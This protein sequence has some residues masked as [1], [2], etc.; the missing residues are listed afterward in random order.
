MTD[1][2]AL[3]ILCLLDV[4][5]LSLEKCLFSVR[6]CM[7]V[8]VCLCTC[9]CGC[10][11]TCPYRHVWRSEGDIGCLSQLLSTVFSEMGLSLSL[12]LHLV[13]RARLTGCEPKPSLCLCPPLVE[14]QA[15][16]AGNLNS[17]PHAVMASTLQPSF[18]HC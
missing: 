17:L 11:C 2:I 5:M 13:I 10:G 14:L 8:C 1:L 7:L 16:S 18:A 15:H 6:V 3:S 9:V 12:E 4:C